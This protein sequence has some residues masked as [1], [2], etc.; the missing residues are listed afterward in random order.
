MELYFERP[1]LTR[2][3]FFFDR[4]D[5]LILHVHDGDL[6]LKRENVIYLYRDAVDTVYSQMVYFGEVLNDGALVEKWAEMYAR[7][8]AKWLIREDF[9]KKKT[10]LRYDLLKSDYQSEF[11]KVLM[12]FG[13]IMDPVRLEGILDRISKSSVKRKTHHDP[14]VVNLGSDYATQRLAFRERWQDLVYEQMIK[15]DVD[16]VAVIAEMKSNVDRLVRNDKQ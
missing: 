9:T 5:Y 8:L 12:H 13:E 10:V 11:S 4:S 16:L 1:L 7:H 14:E 6:N 2:T 15:I 3:F